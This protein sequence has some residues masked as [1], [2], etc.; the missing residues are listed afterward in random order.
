MNVLGTTVFALIEWRARKGLGGEAATGRRT[1]IRG[2]T[3]AYW[4]LRRHGYV[5]V[6][7]NY[8]VPGLRG[9]I[10]LVGYDGRQLAFVEVKTRTGEN[11]EPEEAVTPEKQRVLSRMARRFLADRH[12][13]NAP[14]RFDVVAIRSRPGRRPDVRLHKDAFAAS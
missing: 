8:Q 9:E 2:E 5:L 13:G 10:D 11:A 12:I 7:R 14:W 1:G 4:F 3:Y 6:A